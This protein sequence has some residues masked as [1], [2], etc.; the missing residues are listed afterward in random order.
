MSVETPIIGQQMICPVCGKSF[1]ATN[2]TKF[3]TM[4]AFTCSWDCFK[5]HHIEKMTPIWNANKIKEKEKQNCVNIKKTRKR[6]SKDDL[7]DSEYN[8]IYKNH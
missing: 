2:Q 1:A 7:I 4:N 5:K 8:R 6:K 3:I